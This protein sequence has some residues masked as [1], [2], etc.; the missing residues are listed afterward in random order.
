MLHFN[1][2]YTPDEIKT[3]Y[4]KLAMSL[5][6]DK[7]GDPADFRELQQQYEFKLSQASREPQLPP[8]FHV[9]KAYTYFRA[10]VVYYQRDNHW[11][12]FHKPGGADVWIDRDHLHLIKV[13]NTIAASHFAI[14]D[15]A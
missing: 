5:H 8:F 12:K 14:G 10:K 7:G 1:D 4:R 9:D 15:K 3:R 2:C 13:E 6:P 11:Y